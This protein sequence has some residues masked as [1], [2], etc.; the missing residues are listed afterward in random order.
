MFYLSKRLKVLLLTAA[1]TALLAAAA[2]AAEV[3]TVTASRLNVRSGPSTGCGIL[4]SLTRGAQVAVLEEQDG[5]YR[6]NYGTGE[7]YV[8]AD[9]LTVTQVAETGTVTASSLNVRQSP[10]SGKVL[11]KLPQGTSVTILS[12]DEESG[13]YEIALDGGSGWCSPDYIRR[14][15]PADPADS[16]AFGRQ[17]ADEAAKYL[18]VRYRYGGSSPSTGFDCSGLTSYVLKQCGVTI[19]RRASTQYG[20]GTPVSKSELQPGDLVFFRN[21]SSGSRIGHV[22]IYIGG[23]QYIHAQSAGRPVC[24]ASLSNSWS[25]RYYYGA[26]R[27]TP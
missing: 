27:V 1:L 20:D 16:T 21:S 11:T 19:S 6:V 5:F 3:G 24:I 15:T 25:T 7:G 12:T 10:V 23:D 22:G 9:Y 26:C 4:T 8:S 13:W 18:G 2:S 14:D 17:V